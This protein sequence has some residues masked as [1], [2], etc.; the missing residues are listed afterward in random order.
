[1]KSF[2]LLG[3]LLLVAPF[4]AFSQEKLISEQ[5]FT[6]KISPASINCVDG[7]FGDFGGGVR[8]TLNTS[9][10]S[11]G[12]YYPSKFLNQNTD[13]VYFQGDIRGE[14]CSAYDDILKKAGLLE[15]KG[16]KRITERSDYRP[17]FKACQRGLREELVI[18]VERLSFSGSQSFI[19]FP[20]PASDCE[21]KD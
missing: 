4:S 7:T 18:Q 2:P 17:E 14:A 16:T 9:Y 6:A 20:A 8:M 1:M 5:E 21:F 11:A 13:A 12:I 10:G 15:I 19:V 3:S